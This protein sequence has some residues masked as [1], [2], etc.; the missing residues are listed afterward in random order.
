MME[1]NM[2]KLIMKSLPRLNEWPTFSGTG[3]YDHIEFIDWIDDLQ[4]NTKLSDET[5]LARLGS[6]F[7]QVASK[8]YSARMKIKIAHFGKKKSSNN[9]LPQNGQEK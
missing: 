9:L 8:W 7:K 1:S 3:E 4:S 6:L 5:I 2:H